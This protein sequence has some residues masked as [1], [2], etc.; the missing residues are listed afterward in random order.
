MESK[1]T[2]TFLTQSAMIA[3]IYVVLT[4]G[5]CTVQLRRGAGARL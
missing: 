2:V 1:D 4:A 3:A 5:V